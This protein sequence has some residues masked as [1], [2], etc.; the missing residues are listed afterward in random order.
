MADNTKLLEILAE[1]NCGKCRHL[2][3]MYSQA[4]CYWNGSENGI[5]VFPDYWHPFVCKNF[6][7]LRDGEEF[8]C[9]RGRKP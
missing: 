9:T 4:Y 5:L 8:G 2:G 3:R 1:F 6:E 7:K